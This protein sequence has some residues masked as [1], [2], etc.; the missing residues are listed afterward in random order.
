[1]NTKKNNKTALFIP[2]ENPGSISILEPVARL[3]ESRGWQSVFLSMERVYPYGTDQVY[4]KAGLSYARIAVGRPIIKRNRLRYLLVYSQVR[5]WAKRFLRR[6][7]PAVIISLKN[8]GIP[9]LFI[10][11]A[12]E[13]KIPTLLV[14][15]GIF[16]E[17]RKPGLGILFSA[18]RLSFWLRH[19]IKVVASILA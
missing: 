12:K 15:E 18:R 3:L 5:S 16:C 2:A 8:T 14:Q 10:M 1:M 11:A 17:L 9:G 13:Q 4:D 6:L 19:L 7:K